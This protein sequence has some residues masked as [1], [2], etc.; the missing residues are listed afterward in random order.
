MQPRFSVVIPTYNRS[1]S[2]LDTLRSCFEQTYPS[3]EVVIVDDGSSDDTLAVLAAIDDPSAKKLSPKDNSY[4]KM[5]LY[6]TRG[7]C[8]YMTRGR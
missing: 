3:V 2:V 6:L 8:H 7:R 4:K 5:K 1:L